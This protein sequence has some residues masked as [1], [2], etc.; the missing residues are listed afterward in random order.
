ME[1]GDYNRQRVLALRAEKT[2]ESD[3]V[4]RPLGVSPAEW[5]DRQAAELRAIVRR[6]LLAGAP[7]PF[8]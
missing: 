4:R 8:A 1:T 3:D 5:R 2:G 7:D 6:S